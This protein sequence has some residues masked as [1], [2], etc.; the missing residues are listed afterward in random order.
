VIDRPGVW[1]R[2]VGLSAMIVVGLDL[3]EALASLPPDCDR[4]LARRLLLIAESHFV[5]AFNAR[6]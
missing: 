5:A 2:A 1:T 3:R 4:E 6:P